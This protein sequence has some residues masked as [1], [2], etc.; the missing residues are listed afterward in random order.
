MSSIQKFFPRGEFTPVS[1]EDAINGAVRALKVVATGR[2]SGLTKAECE[3]LYEQIW[4]ITNCSI[5]SQNQDTK[6]ERQKE[7]L[8]KLYKESLAPVAS[9]PMERRLEVY[10]PILKDKVREEFGRTWQ[11]IT[12]GNRKGQNVRD[13]YAIINALTYADISNVSVISAALGKDRTTGL[14]AL[15][16]HKKLLLNPDYKHKFTALLAWLEK[17][18]IKQVG[19]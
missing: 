5:A 8:Q 7:Q 4:Q 12:V 9:L 17:V 15:D 11:E 16:C 1:C 10:L 3:A 13:R 2:S 14:H 18:K 19:K 6:I